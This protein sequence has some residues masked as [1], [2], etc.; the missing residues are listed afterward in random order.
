MQR[1]PGFY[2][3]ATD[4]TSGLPSIGSGGQFTLSGTTPLQPTIY[5][6]SVLLDRAKQLAQLAAPAEAAM[7]AA[8]EKR[9]DHAYTVLRARQDLDI[10]RANASVQDLRLTQ[11]QDGIQLAQLQKSRA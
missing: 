1:V 5:R 7:L 6:Y 8:I 4:S 9:D 2:S 11:A 3:A 10:A